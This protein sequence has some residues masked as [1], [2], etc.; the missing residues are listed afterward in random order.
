MD[1]EK[2]P[3]V[4]A[5]V[6]LSKPNSAR[7]YDWYLGGSGNFEVDRE[8]GRRIMAEFPLVRPTAVSNRRWL[9]R[10]VRAAARAGITQF[11]DLG[12]GVPT[13]GNVHEIAAQELGDGPARVVYVDNEHVACAHAQLT[14]EDQHAQHWCGVVQADFRHPQAV[15]AHPETQRLLDFTAPV[16]VMFASVLHF[17]GP[18][19]DPA[20]LVQRYRATL[21]AG[22]WIAVSQPTDEIEDPEAAEGMRTIMRSYAAA[23]TPAWTRTHREVAAWFDAFTLVEPRLSRAP[24]WRPELDADPELAS[25]EA[26]VRDCYWCVVGQVPTS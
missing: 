24:D 17:I 26:Q 3:S 12:S 22:S 11:L 21:A 6:D 19:D 20:G 9:G 13:V 2:A 10:V 1:A 25:D 18:G 14:L 5:D 4:P 23:G 8:F 16:C 15:L 7:L